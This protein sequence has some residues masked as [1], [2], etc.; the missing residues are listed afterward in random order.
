MCPEQTPK[1]NL[2]ASHAAKHVTFQLSLQSARISVGS[3]EIRLHRLLLACSFPLPIKVPLW[4]MGINQ[5]YFLH[6]LLF[7]MVSKCP[8]NCQLP[9]T[10]WLP[11]NHAPAPS[12]PKIPAGLS[13]GLL[14]DSMLLEIVLSSALKIGR[15]LAKVWSCCPWLP[16]PTHIEKKNTYGNI[17]PHSDSFRRARAFA[18]KSSETW[19]FFMMVFAFCPQLIGFLFGDIF[20]SV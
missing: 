13:E 20:L 4:T 1:P 14:P 5:Q 2:F 12:L 10:L 15:S 8:H 19:L 17:S 18:S 11:Q 3:L 7:G 6:G 9:A 16:P